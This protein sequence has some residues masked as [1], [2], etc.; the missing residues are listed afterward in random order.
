MVW[1][2]FRFCEIWRIQTDKDQSGLDVL[3]RSRL[4]ALVPLGL[5]GNLLDLV[6]QGKLSPLGRTDCKIV[7]GGRAF[8]VFDLAVD[9][10]VLFAKSLNMGLE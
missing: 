8:E 3:T 9:K 5:V 4:V 1:A 6:L 7:G 10:G 2:V